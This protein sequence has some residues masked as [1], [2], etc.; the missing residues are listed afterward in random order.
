MPNKTLHFKGDA[1]IG[2]KSS[3]E[4]IT[5]LVCAN[6]DGSEKLRLLVIGKSKNPRCLKGIKTLP[7]DYVSNTKAW[8]TQDIF[9]NWLKGIDKQ[10]SRQKR[11]ILLFVD[12]ATCHNNLPEL[13]SIQVE[14][15][16]P[17][18]IGRSVKIFFSKFFFR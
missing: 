18:T 11:K 3:K 2:G 1:C 13:S 15:L 8:M 6:M 4:R 10:F 12:N 7:F 14:Y 16:P 17:N 5:A 9:S